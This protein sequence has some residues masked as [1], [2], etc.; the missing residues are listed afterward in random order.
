MFRRTITNYC[1]N[2]FVSSPQFGVARLVAGV[3]VAG[4]FVIVE[5]WLLHGDKPIEPNV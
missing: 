4:V 3:A 1:S 2:A 5:S